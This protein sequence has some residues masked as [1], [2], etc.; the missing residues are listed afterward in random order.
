MNEHPPGHR[1]FLKKMTA[2]GAAGLPIVT[3][4]A[5]GPVYAADAAS[6]LAPLR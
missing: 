4:T 1:K 6:L 2:L 3:V 5:S